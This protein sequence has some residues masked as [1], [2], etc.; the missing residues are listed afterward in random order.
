MY[1]RDIK[2]GTT[3]S[4]SEPV[5]LKESPATALVDGNNLLG[6]CFVK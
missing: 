3:S 2:E 4:S 6:C 5:I 1:V